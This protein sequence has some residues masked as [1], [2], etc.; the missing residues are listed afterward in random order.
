VPLGGYTQ[1]VHLVSEPEEAIQRQRDQVL[2]AFPVL[3]RWLLRS[4]PAQRSPSGSS[5]LPVSHIRVLVHLYQQGPMPMG[6]L[7]RGLGIACSTATECVAGLE[8]RGRV[9]RARSSSD[10]RQVMVSM[11]PEAEAIASRVLS[12]R[13]AV[14]EGVL[15]QLSPRQVKA[16][17]QGMELLA[18]GAETWMDRTASAEQGPVLPTQEGIR[19]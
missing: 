6:E 9:V 4:S 2:S 15:R 18:T 1:S 7:A 14:V 3:R 16:F 13:Q 8:A 10:R 12:Q 5:P 17:V 19:V 11:T